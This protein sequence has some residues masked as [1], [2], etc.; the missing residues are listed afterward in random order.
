MIDTPPSFFRKHLDKTLSG[1]SG[2]VGINKL[3]PNRKD[4]FKYMAPISPTTSTTTS[5]HCQIR[6]LNR[7]EA[8]EK[9][10]KTIASHAICGLGPRAKEGSGIPC[11]GEGDLHL[12]DLIHSTQNTPSIKSPKRYQVQKGILKE[13]DNNESLSKSKFKVNPIPLDPSNTSLP[14]I[15]PKKLGK[16]NQKLTFSEF[17]EKVGSGSNISINREKSALESE[18]P[19]TS[20]S[21]TTKTPQ[22]YRRN[23]GLSS[24]SRTHG[25]NFY[26][27][28]VCDVKQSNRR[29]QPPP[30]CSQPPKRKMIS[31][32][33]IGPN[34]HTFEK[35]Y[36]LKGL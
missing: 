33:L 3:I 17:V 10:K 4:L 18:K 19:E 25:R 27:L 8:Q 28:L 36:T 23:H 16:K 1:T 15:S 22:I 24:P 14:S 9:R 13:R 26:C 7:A 20:Q 6:F 29:G 12:P 34:T 5:P 11:I 31:K 2:R 35:P 30:F 21:P 32:L